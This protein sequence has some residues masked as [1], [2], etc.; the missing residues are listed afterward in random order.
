MLDWF[1]LMC[2]LRRGH[3]PSCRYGLRRRRRLRS[4]HRL[5]HG[6]LRG[7]RRDRTGRSLCHRHLLRLRLHGALCAAL[8]CLRSVLLGLRSMGRRGLRALRLW[9]FLRLRGSL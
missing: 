5:G 4:W 8:L 9:C 1:R 2:R 6:R 3:R 7:L